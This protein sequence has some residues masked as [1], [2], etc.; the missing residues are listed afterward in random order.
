MYSALGA[1]FSALMRYIL[2]LFYLLTTY[3]LH[4]VA[5][6]VLLIVPAHGGMTRLS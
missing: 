1:V 4:P 5:C 3:L 6:K 2:L